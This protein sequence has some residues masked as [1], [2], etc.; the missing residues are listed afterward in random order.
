MSSRVVMESRTKRIVGVALFLSSMGPALVDGTVACTSKSTSETKPSSVIVIGLSASLK[1][2]N[3]GVGAVIRDGTQCA[4]NLINAR[5]G[6]LGKSLQLDVGDDASDNSGQGGNILRGVINGFLDRH[7]TAILGPGAS[8]Q[9]A[10]AQRAAFLRDDAGVAAPG[11]QPT[12]VISAWATSPSIT[13]IQPPWPNRYLYRTVPSDLFQS[14]AMFKVMTEGSSVTAD[15]G[16][17]IDGGPGATRRCQRPFLVYTTDIVGQ[18]YFAYLPGAFSKIGVELKTTSV[19]TNAISDYTAQID[20][21]IAARADCIA[22][23]GYLDPAVAMLPKL[24]E[25]IDTA[26]RNNNYPADYSLI[27]NDALNDL[28]FIDEIKK[29]NGQIIEGMI[30][31]APDTAPL[32]REYTEF[33]TLLQTHTG[34]TGRKDGGEDDAAYAANAFDAVVLLALALQMAGTT[35]DTV[36]IRDALVAVSRGYPAG[37]KT[38][39]GVT[40]KIVGPGTLDDAFT[41]ISTGGAID[42]AGASGPVDFDDNGDV[43][44]TYIKWT[45][46]DGRFH[47]VNHYVPADLE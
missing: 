31:V 36:K 28:K 11:T 6:V 17:P 1:G 47:T 45:I 10:D 26:K 35:T 46:K 13:T 41:A 30:G 4:V 7:V 2:S 27:G 42:Y 15:A 12:L 21:I 3:A 18:G 16:V 19:P 32:T 37:Q 14:R 44:G 23:A 29:T 9:L 22:L 34:R 20:Q 33:Q 8:V 38:S 39:V 43:A 24:R 25:A 40:P 5:G